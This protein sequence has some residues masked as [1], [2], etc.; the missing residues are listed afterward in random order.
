MKRADVNQTWG[1]FMHTLLSPL[2]H[3]FCIFGENWEYF[4]A[5]DFHS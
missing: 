3:G 5:R 2:K 1:S 4:F